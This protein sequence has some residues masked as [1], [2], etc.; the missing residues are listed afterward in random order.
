MIYLATSQTP[1]Y[2]VNELGFFKMLRSVPAGTE[3]T[4]TTT[5]IDD[6]S[7]RPIGKLETGEIVYLDK[8]TKTLEAVEVK[9]KFMWWY[10]SGILLVITIIIVALV[11]SNA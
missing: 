7:D 2:Q 6:K 1:L 5:I 9:G 11:K 8:L 10:I 4:I 3:L